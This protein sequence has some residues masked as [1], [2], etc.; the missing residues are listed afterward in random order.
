MK[1]LKLLTIILS[2]ILI[3][4]CAM[5]PMKPPADPSN[6]IKRIAIL[7]IKNDT[8]D[9]G[10]PN[11]VREK[12]VEAFEDRYYNVK[13]VEETDRLLRDRMGIT[14]GGQLEM[15]KIEKLREVLDV[16]GLVFGTLM[17]F[18]ETTTGF[19]NVR[20]VRGKFKLTNTLTNE[21][22]W[23]NGIGVKSEESA[24]GLLGSATALAAGIKGKDE[25]VPWVII[26]SRSSDK[27]VLDSL[28][29][30]LAKK[31]VSKITKTHLLRE[32]NEMIRRI[33]ENLPWGPGTVTVASAP[34]KFKIPKVKMP[35]P[36]SVGHMDY[37]KRDFSA[38]MVSN[39]VDKR[40]KDSFGFEM[41]IA[42]AGKK[43]RL[44]M[45]YSKMPQGAQMPP[46]L[47]KMVTIHR[48]D[49]KVTYSLYPNKKKY[50]GHDV[51][52]EN[53]YEK[54]DVTKTRVG[55]ETIDGHPTEKFKIKITYKNAKTQ[56]GYIWNATDLYG[57]TI[58]SETV[59]EN[60]KFTT[61]LKNI[62]L[63]TPPKNLFEIPAGFTEASGFM[64]L[65]M[66]EK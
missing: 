54:P 36:P 65:M 66:E 60:F 34:V 23:A 63:K 14:L 62:V 17:D 15:A 64:E 35:P 4:G 52:D 27:S 7:P 49:K 43:I 28:A 37:G 55:S 51:T 26:E 41:P 21:T 13:P 9:V 44:E 47:S 24:G 5:L 22:F 39:M 3:S 19:Y 48:G 59:D 61:R 25:E 8:N 2:I 6:P 10:G 46:A 58:K 16:E 30:G 56:Q 38:V 11:F 12:L 53:Y 33:L 18:G 50:L 20:K 40:G 42:K 45:D 1:S 31:L 29:A 57:M 32:T